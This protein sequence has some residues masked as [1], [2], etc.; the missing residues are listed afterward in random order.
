VVKS[1]EDVK[2]DDVLITE[3]VDGQV[4]SKVEA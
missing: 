2:V 1:V 4:I 3:L